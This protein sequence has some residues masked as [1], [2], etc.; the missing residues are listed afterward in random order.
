MPP[1]EELFTV[2]LGEAKWSVRFVD[3][4]GSLVSLR[5]L[6]NSG[7][8]PVD[9]NVYWDKSTSNFDELPDDLPVK[10]RTAIYR[11]MK[12]HYG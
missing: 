5:V 8:E 4:D 7:A 12:T 2:P 9:P 3:V 6:V 10:V 11:W 1:E